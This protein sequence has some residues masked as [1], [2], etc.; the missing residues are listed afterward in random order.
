VDA[1]GLAKRFEASAR[2]YQEQAEAVTAA[3]R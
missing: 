2:T 1:P 3:I